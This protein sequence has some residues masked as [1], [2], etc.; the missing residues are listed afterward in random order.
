MRKNSYIWT[1]YSFTQSGQRVYVC[2]LRVFTKKVYLHAAHNMF[3][4]PGMAGREMAMGKGL[5]EMD[6][7]GGRE[8][9]EERGGEGELE[10][11]AKI[12]WLMFYDTWSQLIYAVSCIVRG[13]GGG[14]GGGG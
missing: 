14:G 13:G 7:E 8:G 3:V 11:G 12:C 5:G 9:G 6:P 4:F 2:G 1:S 10:K